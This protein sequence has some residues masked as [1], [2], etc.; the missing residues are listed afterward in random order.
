[1][2]I[3]KVMLVD[4]ETIVI[5]DMMSLIDWEKNGYKVVAYAHDGENALQLFKS[6]MPDIVFID[7]CL[8]KMSGLEFAKAAHTINPGAKLLILS[9][10]SDFEY[11]KLAIDIGIM[12]YLLKHRINE[13]S[14]LDILSKA[15]E[16]IDQDTR[17][18]GSIRRELLL[19]MIR[20]GDYLTSITPE[21]ERFLS[22]YRSKFFL[23]LEKADRPFPIIGDIEPLP[24]QK[25][26]EPDFSLISMPSGLFLLD[27]L[28]VDVDSFLLI[29]ASQGPLSGSI[30]E[31]KLSRLAADLQ[32]LLEGDTGKTYSAVYLTRY[33][34]L[35]ML[36][37]DFIL[38]K[39]CLDSCFFCGRRYLA[40]VPDFCKNIP[41]SVRSTLQVL[42]DKIN[43]KN[44]Q[45]DFDLF[46][47]SIRQIF[48]EITAVRSLPLLKEQCMQLETLL[49]FIRNEKHSDL[50]VQDEDGPDKETV[51]FDAASIC[52][53][54]ISRFTGL[55]E[56]QLMLSRYSGIIHNAI[57]YVHENYDNPITIT[58]VADL[59]GV[60]GMYLGQK[61]KR[62]TNMGLGDY[63]NLCRINRA[64]ALLASGKYKVY[65][66]AEMVG[67]QNSQYFSKVFKE[68]TGVTPHEYRENW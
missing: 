28:S 42:A 58:E 16:A 29:L 2:R 18:E 13:K 7:I 37:R 15:R 22:A 25:N 32:A 65:Q 60:N 53:W 61:F 56:D 41:P 19:R 33:S 38:M 24:A 27:V 23:I 1:M 9:G 67:F 21:E 36:C 51:F 55:R 40:P 49:K 3:L 54:F 26:Y 4:D 35:S 63:I 59:L 31:S 34:S 17:T 44:F 46:I 45:H 66:I 20:R 12:S 47:A 5:S 50:K 11:A 52:N 57:K 48:Q 6:H 10:Y 68:I 43:Y 8:P 30:P 14:L 62:E 39:E 64:K